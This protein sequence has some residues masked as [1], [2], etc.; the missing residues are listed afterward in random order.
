[1]VGNVDEKAEEEEVEEEE[2][3]EKEEYARPY[4]AGGMSA[5]STRVSV[6]VCVNSPKT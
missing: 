3:A 1:M 4:R 6:S 2:G 5:E